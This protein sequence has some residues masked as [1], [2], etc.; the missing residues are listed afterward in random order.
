[1]AAAPKEL[2]LAMTAR[3]SELRGV[4]IV[5]LHTEGPAP[6]TAPELS[7][8]FRVNS[9]FIGASTRQAVQEGRADYVPIFLS[10]VPA[11][12]RSGEMPI[13]VALIQ[14]SSPDRHGFCSL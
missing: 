1:M 9:L 14:V 2:I 11:L 6:Y 3:S 7:N 13:D 5:Q 12:F 8:S 4:E 10:E